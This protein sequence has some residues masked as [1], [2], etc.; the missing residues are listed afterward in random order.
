M[1]P[2]CHLCSFSSGNSPGATGTVPTGYMPSTGP[3]GT[4]TGGGAGST[5]LNANNPGGNSMYDSPTSLTAGSGS[6][7]CGWLLCL[8]WMITF[9]FVKEKV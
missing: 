2:S 7:S 4:A 9:A 8:I 5:V 3:T 1:Q 6:L